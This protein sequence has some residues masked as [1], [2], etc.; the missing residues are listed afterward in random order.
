MRPWDSTAGAPAKVSASMPTSVISLK[1]PSCMRA[2]TK[3]VW[4]GAAQATPS[5]E[6][7]RPRSVSRSGLASLTCSTIGSLTQTCARMLT[8]GV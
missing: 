4:R 1:L 8:I 7:T 3:D 5:T 2:W 6:R